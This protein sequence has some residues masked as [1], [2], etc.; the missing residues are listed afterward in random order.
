MNKQLTSYQTHA[1]EDTHII[2]GATGR[3]ANIVPITAVEIITII[4]VVY[5]SQFHVSVFENL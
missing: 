2:V 5:A 3:K 4:R 1:P